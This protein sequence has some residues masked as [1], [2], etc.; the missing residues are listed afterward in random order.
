MTSQI[1]RSIEASCVGKL[2]RKERIYLCTKVYGVE[3]PRKPPG[4]PQ[5]APRKPPESPQET[6]RY[7]PG[8]QKAPRKPQGSRRKPQKAPRKPP[9]KNDMTSQID[10]VIETWEAT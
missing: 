3:A 4:S 5:E 2:H 9:T 7:P 6:P 8:P 10:R 1:D